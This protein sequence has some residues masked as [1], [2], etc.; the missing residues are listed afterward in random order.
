MKTIT[1]YKRSILERTQFKKWRYKE[2][3]QISIFY[4]NEEHKNHY[5]SIN[6][7]RLKI[8]FQE[9]LKT[10]SKKELEK[11]ISKLSNRDVDKWQKSTLIDLINNN[12]K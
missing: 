10:R 3:D 9:V 11:Y 8:K 2:V 1:I 12:N 5:E 6:N 4:N 7:P